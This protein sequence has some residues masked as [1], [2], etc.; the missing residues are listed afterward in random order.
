M[1]HQPET[2]R[3][4]KIRSLFFTDQMI[5]FCSF[6]TLIISQSILVILS[7]LHWNN[8]VSK[9]WIPQC[10]FSFL[11]YFFSQYFPLCHI[12]HIILFLLACKRLVSSLCC[13]VRH[14][15]WFFKTV[16]FRKVLCIR[17][18]KKEVSGLY[19]EVYYNIVNTR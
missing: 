11:V 5:S 10:T 9:W 4:D 2:H 16:S 14:L 1:L 6:G 17:K 3:A 8:Y 13:L 12:L 18:Y 19:N 7:T 15:M